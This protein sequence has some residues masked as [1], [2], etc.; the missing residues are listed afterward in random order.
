M[1]HAAVAMAL[2]SKTVSGPT[3]WF[4]EAG[5]VLSSDDLKKE[6]P[7]VSRPVYTALL[8]CHSDTLMV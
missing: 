3:V 4:P 6:D 2:R 1:Q 5:D 7:C 8:V